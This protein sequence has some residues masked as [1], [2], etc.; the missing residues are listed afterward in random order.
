MSWFLFGRFGTPAVLAVLARDTITREQAVA[1]STA[2]MQPM[3]ADDPVRMIKAEAQWFKR[4]AHE[5]FELLTLPVLQLLAAGV[6]VVFVLIRSQPMFQLPFANLEEALA[7]SPLWSRV[8]KPPKRVP[9]A[10]AATVRPEPVPQG[11]GQ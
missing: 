8:G 4:E 2:T 7:A 5:F 11:G 3:F 10:D 9:P 6:N 1:T